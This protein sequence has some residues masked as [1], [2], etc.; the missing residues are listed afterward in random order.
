MLRSK[1]SASGQ[2]AAF[3]DYRF[4]SDF[5]VPDFESQFPGFGSCLSRRGLSRAP[6]LSPLAASASPRSSRPCSGSSGT[7]FARRAPPE[8]RVPVF[9]F[10]S[11]V[12]GFRILVISFRSACLGVRVLAWAP[13]R[14]S[15]VQLSKPSMQ[16]V[17]SVTTLSTSGI[18]LLF[19]W[20]ADAKPHWGV[21]GLVFRICYLGFRIWGLGFSI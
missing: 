15:T 19:P 4:G 11:L 2:R 9:G 10:W 13:K 14:W 6:R 20:Q 12:F 18:G 1:N 7:A 3:Q 5:R 16:V 21:R 8:F 17:G